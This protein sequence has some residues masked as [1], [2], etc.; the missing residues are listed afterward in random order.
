MKRFAIVIA[1]AT[2]MSAGAQTKKWTLQECVEYAMSNNISLKQ[3]VLD[4]E[5]AR[6]EKADAVGAYLPNLNGSLSNSWN[7]GLT[8]NV[9]TGCIGKSNF[10][11][12]IL[13]CNCR[14]FSFSR[15]AEF[16]EFAARQNKYHGGSVWFGENAG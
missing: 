9:T 8:Q 11:K 14:Y 10:S 2:I 7:T 4:Q 3:S 6:L 16:K 15:V 1:L 5:L 12:L 13:Q